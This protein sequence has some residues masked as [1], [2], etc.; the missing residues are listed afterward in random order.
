V[1]W[2]PNHYTRL[3]AN[4]TVTEC[5]TPIVV[6]GINLDQEKALTLRAQVDF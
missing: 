3:M 1:K 5:D 6:N 4:Y 2:I